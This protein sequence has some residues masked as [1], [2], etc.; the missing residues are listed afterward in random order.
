MTIY[1]MVFNAAFGTNTN[2]NVHFQVVLFSIAEYCLEPCIKR[3]TDMPYNIEEKTLA[4][5]S[6]RSGF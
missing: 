2:K 5:D 6:E 4:L 3:Q 1:Q